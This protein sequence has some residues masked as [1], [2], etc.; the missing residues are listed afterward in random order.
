MH[1][2]VP[3]AAVDKDLIQRETK[4]NNVAQ[5]DSVFD[6]LLGKRGFRKA[7]TLDEDSKADSMFDNLLGNPT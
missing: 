6:N 5:A 7:D 2:I 3:E 4:Y 1:S